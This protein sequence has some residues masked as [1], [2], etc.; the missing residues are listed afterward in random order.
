MLL[1]GEKKEEYREIKDYWKSRLENYV[2]AMGWAHGSHFYTFKE[3]DQVIFKNGY[4][5]NAPTA[6]FEC[7]GIEKR[8]G[9]KEWGANECQKYY[10]IALG[11]LLTYSNCL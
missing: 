6:I 1:S 2:P 11:K 3:F 9:R 4:S 8:T 10:C 5:K 7:K